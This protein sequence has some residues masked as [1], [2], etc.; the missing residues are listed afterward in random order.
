MTSPSPAS[1]SSPIPPPSPGAEPPADAVPAP[2]ACPI[3]QLVNQ[4]LEERYITQ[5]QYQ[6]LSALVLADG[7]VDE[8]ERHQINR[9]FDAIQTGRVKIR[10]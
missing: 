6:T 10:A 7:T 9:L 8:S 4:V 3:T 5:A 2:D 1:P